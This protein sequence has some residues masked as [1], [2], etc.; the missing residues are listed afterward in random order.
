[1]SAGSSS[2]AASEHRTMSERTPTVEDRLKLLQ[3]PQFGG[4]RAL[5]P[6]DPLKTTPIVVSVSQIQ[7]YDRNPRAARNEAYDRIK[8]S[9]RQRGFNGVLRIT[10]RPGQPHYIVAQGGNTTLRILK[11]LYAE[12]RDPKFQS[13]SCLYEPWIS[14]CETL[15]AHLVENDARGDLIFIDRARALRDLRRLLVQERG[16]A[17]STRELAALLRERGYSIDPATITR[18]DYA[19]E[20][21][22]PLIPL[23]L[24]AGLGRPAID[25]I[26][27]LEKML[28]RCLKER[29]LD[30]PVIEEVRQWFLL[31]LSRHDRGDWLLEPVQQEAEAYFADLCGVSR[32]KVRA[33][34]GPADILGESGGEA[35]PSAPVSTYEHP[36]SPGS[37]P[38]L[39]QITGEEPP[40]CPRPRQS[41]AL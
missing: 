12:T 22:L 41:L 15:I 32:E 6:A 16:M 21:L 9:I 19:R 2:R 33:A 30:Q 4:P 13:I 14:E 24:R 35:S 11:E 38:E 23:A 39:P 26:R 36:R 5:K 1:M 31:C 28:V 40:M 29:E 25:R 3:E 20:T 27:K 7:E 17:L 34:L 37:A 8:E 10:R 18:L